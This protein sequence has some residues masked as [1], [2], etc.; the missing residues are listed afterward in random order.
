MRI[1]SQGGC[2]S[3]RRIRMPTSTDHNR[4]FDPAEQSQRAEWTLRA[5][6]RSPILSQGGSDEHAFSIDRGWFMARLPG[7]VATYMDARVDDA[8]YARFLSTLA[9]DIDSTPVQ[10]RRGVLYEAPEALGVGADRRK[11]LAVLLEARRE[12]LAQITAGYVLVTP[13]AVA[14]GVLTAVFWLAPPPYQTHVTGTLHDAFAWLAQRVPQ[15]N[16]A[17]A[18]LAYLNVR[19][20]ALAKMRP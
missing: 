8:S 1:L 19:A 7:V 3:A 14:R 4:R 16:A 5:V 9:D 6:T 18:E 15:L 20:D 2:C 17:E 12:S 13:S 10:Q 11:K